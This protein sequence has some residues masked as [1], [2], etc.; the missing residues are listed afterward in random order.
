[1]WRQ[2]ARSARSALRA[3][4]GAAATTTAAAPAL[5]E[6]GL[7]VAARSLHAHAGS[8]ARGGLLATVLPDSSFGSKSSACLGACPSRLYATAQDSEL[9]EIV[10]SEVEHEEKGYKPPKAV[11]RGPPSP[12]TLMDKP[13]NTELMLHRSFHGEDVA[14]A[15]TV[16]L[17]V[18]EPDFDEDEDEHE[19]EEEEE[20]DEMMMDAPFTVTI[21]KPNRERLVFECSASG[22]DGS[23]SIG[24]TTLEGN[25]TT[26]IP[27]EGPDFETLDPE[28]QEQFHEYLTERGITAQYGKYLVALAADKEQREYTS[29][30]KRLKKFLDQ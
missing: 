19:E 12:W 16:N 9:R 20:E 23:I 10:E 24:H 27:Y 28:L 17:E 29:W 11:K 8:S 7:A 21:T 6:E 18:P 2:A 5:R 3:R 14:V 13:G 25:A 1:M 30:L 4:G 22:Q 15:L 26:G